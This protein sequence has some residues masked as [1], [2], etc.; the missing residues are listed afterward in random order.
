MSEQISSTETHQPVG[1]R[2]TDMGLFVRCSCGK[3]PT[4]RYWLEDHWPGDEAE[5]MQL[6][7]DLIARVRE[8]S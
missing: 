5:G 7:K 8:I 1:I 3:I 4:P 6:V 2:S